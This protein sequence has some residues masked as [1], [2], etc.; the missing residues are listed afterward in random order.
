MISDEWRIGVREL[1]NNWCVAPLI[2]F[3]SLIGLYTNKHEIFLNGNGTYRRFSAFQKVNTDANHKKMSKILLRTQYTFS[4]CTD[5][6]REAAKGYLK[7]RIS[8]ILGMK[9]PFC[10]PAN[11]IHFFFSS[12]SY[13]LHSETAATELGGERHKATTNELV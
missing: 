2:I 12:H 5:H 7:R 4:W 1:N 13:N 11:F 10:Q 6:L 9:R 8:I 3:Q